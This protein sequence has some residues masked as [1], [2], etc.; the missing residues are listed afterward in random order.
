M[1][2]SQQF[3]RTAAGEKSSGGFYTE[4]FRVKIVGTVFLQHFVLIQTKAT[5]S[6]NE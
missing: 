1:N 4:C 5:A 3:D 6:L 2:T